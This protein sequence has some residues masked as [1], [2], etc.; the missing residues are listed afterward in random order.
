MD[1]A[2]PKKVD[3]PLLGAWLVLQASQAPMGGRVELDR[4][5]RCFRLRKARPANE[6]LLQGVGR[7]TVWVGAGVGSE[8]G[9][10]Q[11]SH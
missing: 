8:A 5:Q 6:H 9:T 11:R 7:A 2:T 1:R 3:L 10:P 4:G